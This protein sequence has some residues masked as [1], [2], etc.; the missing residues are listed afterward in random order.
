MLGLLSPLFFFFGWDWLTGHFSREV[1][2]RWRVWWAIILSRAVVL[3]F[4]VFPCAYQ[5]EWAIPSLC[6]YS[7]LQFMFILLPFC[8]V[9]GERSK[10]FSS[11]RYLANTYTRSKNKSCKNFPS[12]FEINFHRIWWS[13]FTRRKS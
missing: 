7:S 4:S 1:N 11:M 10:T 9:S 2:L 3:N 12:L 5:S 13:G 8:F 6:Q